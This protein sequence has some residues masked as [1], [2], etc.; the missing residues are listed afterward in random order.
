MT[1]KSKASVL[2][3]LPEPY[4]FDWLDV[5]DGH[6]IYFEQ[7]GN[8]AG[9]PVVVLHGGPGG[10]GD[11]A[12]R[13]FFDPDLYRIVVFDQR[14]AGRSRPHA[15]L[16]ANTTQHLID[17][18][19]R[20][21]AHLGIDRWQVFGGSW[22][23]TLALAYAQAWPHRV[24][25]LVL[26][27]I[28][29]LRK[30]ELDWFYRPGGASQIYPDA[31]QHYERHIPPEERD[32]LPAAYYRRLT[33]DDPEIRLAAA[34]VWSVWEAST[35]CLT[36]SLDMV[37]KF[38]EATLAIAF[39]RIECHYFMNNG[40]MEEGQLLDNIDKIRDIPGVI[41]QGRYDVVCPMRSAFDLSQRW[42][43]ASLQIV[44]D[45][46]HSA[47]EHGIASRLIAATNRFA[48]S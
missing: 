3:P 42:P 47:F 22:G 1:Q 2:F 46:G 12:I 33:S 28:F 11:T 38:G 13:R 8:P 16:K 37:D 39:A 26:R 23:S 31:W 41:V 17:D 24:T 40:F 18:I 35:S 25:E 32:D 9:K 19:E 6:E 5:G 48:E 7:C 20:L 10:G 14:G 30:H 43:K 15:E 27:G 44:P 36:P 34:R 4:Q 21:R 45:A 29:L